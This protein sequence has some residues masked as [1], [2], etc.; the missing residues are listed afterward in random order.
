MKASSIVAL[1]TILT[2]FSGCL[3][4]DDVEQEATIDPFTINKDTYQCFEFEERER[5]WLTY[6]PEQIT[7]T[8]KAPVI[9]ELHGWSASSF[10][11]RTLSDMILLADEVDAILI[12]PE[13]IADPNSGAFGNN[14]ESW[15]SGYCCGDAKQLEINDVGFLSELIN[16]TVQDL[17]VDEK[18]IYLTGWSNG[19]QMSQRMAL[20]ASHLIAAV[21]C[22]SGYLGVTETSNYNPIPV[23]EMHGFLDEIAL[24]TN[25]VRLAFFEDDARNTEAMQN[26]AIENLYDWA[27]HNGCSGSITDENQPNLFY[28]VQSFNSC[29]NNSTVAL[30]SVYA[31]GHNLYANDAGEIGGYPLPGNQGLYDTNKIIWNFVSQYS[32]D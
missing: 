10:E 23:L 6:I 2:A 22:T 25:S 24:Y 29:E 19:C 32:K 17:P 9:M 27:S 28:T 12:H 4:A 7:R 21:A 11:Q 18:R 15:N 1:L 8:S 20:E 13:G 26:G 31:G 5:C 16:R 3:G 14:E 30:V